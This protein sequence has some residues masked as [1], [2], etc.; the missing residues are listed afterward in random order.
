MPTVTVPKSSATG[1]S[2]IGAV[3]VEPMTLMYSSEVLASDWI[4]TAPLRTV[5]LVAAVGA[6]VA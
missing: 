4:A 3:E 2:V 6:K 5:V 1:L